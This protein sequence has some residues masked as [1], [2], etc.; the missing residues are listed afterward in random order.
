MT[1]GPQLFNESFNTNKKSNVKHLIDDG[2]LAHLSDFDD[3]DELPKNDIQLTVMVFPDYDGTPSIKERDEICND[4]MANGWTQVTHV[5]SIESG[6][7][8][9]HYIAFNFEYYS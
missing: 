6:Q 5:N 8:Q 7:P 3:A 1:L 4:Y 9:Q 2:L